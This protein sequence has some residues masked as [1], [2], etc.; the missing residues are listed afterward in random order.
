[1]TRISPSR[2]GSAPPASPGSSRSIRGR[3][4]DF[5]KPP[6]PSTRPSPSK[7][8][9]TSGSFWP[10]FSAESDRVDRSRTNRAAALLS[11]AS[12][13]GRSASLAHFERGNGG[14]SAGTNPPPALQNETSG[15]EVRERFRAV[16]V[17]WLAP[18]FQDRG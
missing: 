16:Q 10:R 3:S 4:T 2:R 13:S 7:R 6:P 5:S 14:P 1:M 17:D 8:S 18:V 15:G 9:P 12:R 11:A